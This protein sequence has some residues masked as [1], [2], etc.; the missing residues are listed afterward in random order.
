MSRIWVLRTA[1]AAVAGIAMW[2]AFPPHTWWFCA[3]IGTG[4]LFG[5][6]SIGRPRAR[7]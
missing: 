7:T 6:L 5:V 2:A 3:V 1:V 4:L